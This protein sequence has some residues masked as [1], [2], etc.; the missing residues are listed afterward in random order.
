ML[1]YSL[2]VSSKCLYNLHRTNPCFSSLCDQELQKMFSGWSIS[3]SSTKRQ[4]WGHQ[5]TD[6]PLAVAAGQ[7]GTLLST[8]P[9]TGC[10]AELL[11]GITFLPWCGF[12][13]Q[14]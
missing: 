5:C 11:C 2:I 3:G 8:R 6:I 10:D 14:L 4:G 9:F 1:S 12:E 13:L 7:T